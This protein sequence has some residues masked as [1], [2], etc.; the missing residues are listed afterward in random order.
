MFDHLFKLISKNIFDLNL[1]QVA[2]LSNNLQIDLV[3][4]LFF[5]Q[6]YYLEINLILDHS[7]SLFLHISGD[8]RYNIFL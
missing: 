8:L 7:V 5:G 1:N 3:L 2:D 6:E 4:D